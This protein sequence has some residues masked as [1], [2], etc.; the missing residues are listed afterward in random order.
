MPKSKRNKIGACHPP[1]KLRRRVSMLVCMEDQGET[2]GIIPLVCP[3]LANNSLFM[4]PVLKPLQLTSDPLTLLLCSVSDQGQ[5][6]GERVEGGTGLHRARACRCVSTSMQF[7]P[8]TLPVGALCTPA[9][10]LS[11]LVCTILNQHGSGAGTGID[12]PCWLC[13]TAGTQQCTSSG[14]TTCAMRPSRSFARSSR[15]EAGQQ[16]GS[17]GRQTRK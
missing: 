1:P 16:L 6:E 15:R 14:S 10:A 4:S 3:F 2:C 8:Y 9:T 12:M 7:I 5:E 17:A 11:C 13:N